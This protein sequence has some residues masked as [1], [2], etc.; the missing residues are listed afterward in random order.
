MEPQTWAMVG[1]GALLLVV[2]IVV[3]AMATNKGGG[4][5][6]HRGKWRDVDCNACPADVDPAWQACGF[7]NMCK[8]RCAPDKAAR[9]AAFKCHHGRGGGGGRHAAA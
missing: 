7:P 2:V 5:G 9:K 4:R 8:A 1:G 6:R 3:V